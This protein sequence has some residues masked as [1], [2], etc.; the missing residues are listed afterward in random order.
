MANNSILT[1]DAMTSVVTPIG[2]ILDEFLNRIEAFDAGLA[3]V[4]DEN[5]SYETGIAKWRQ[6]NATN[7]NNISTLPI[8]IF[9][10]SV[11]RAEDEKG[12]GL[13]SRNFQV[14]QLTENNTTKNF[15]AFFGAFDIDFLYVTKNML[16][17]ERFELTYLQQSG[18]SKTKNIVID[19]PELGERDYSLEY[20]PLDEKTINIDNSYYKILSGTFI[21]RGLFFTFKSETG[22]IKTI[23]SK[24]QDYVVGTK[25]IEPTEL[26][27]K[28]TIDGGPPITTILE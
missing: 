8:F 22:F 7:P 3:Y 25:P 12:N 14:K 2:F 1:N 21:I 10:R 17:L 23:K 5:L 13:R 6:D 15:Q 26:L 16:D 20:G 27:G 28:I 4:M 11:L 18:L 9:R 19:F 24:I